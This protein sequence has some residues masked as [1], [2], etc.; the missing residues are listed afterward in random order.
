MRRALTAGAAY[1]GLVFAAGFALGAIRTLMVEP[2]LGALA[3]V[4]I[5]LPVMLA[6]SWFACGSALR[7]FVVP[8]EFAARLAMGLAAFAVLMGA[9][10]GL[11][12]FVF[13]RSAGD[14]LAGFAAPA[15]A[16]GLAG[17]IAFG[18]MPLA[19]K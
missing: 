4:A 13:A 12:L 19:R 5:E 14:F 9:E 10:L 11:A 15:G 6:I 18:L 1:A 7:R 16:L 2:R 17:Q 8:A 3:A